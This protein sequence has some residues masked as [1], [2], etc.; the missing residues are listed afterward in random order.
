MQLE[1]V[2]CKGENT[3]LAR[4]WY[5]FLFACGNCNPTKGTRVSSV[6][7]LRSVLWPHKDS[8]YR[9]FTYSAAGFVAVNPAASIL[10]Q[11]KAAALAELV[12]LF[13]RP[14]NGL[15]VSQLRDATD[16]RYQLRSEAWEKAVE[17]RRDLLG[18][19][20][21]LAKKLLVELAAATGFWSCWFTVFRHD[22]DVLNGL[23][24]GFLGT[25]ANRV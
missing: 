7:D 6:H 15:T 8:T 12:G 22:R 3:D 9:A 16:I 23:V 13:K 11:R 24:S 19:P 2:R 18:E 1:H 10:A 5:N 14:G 17:M 25:C 21:P 4:N 20:S